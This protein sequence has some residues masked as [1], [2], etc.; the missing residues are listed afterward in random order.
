MSRQYIQSQ[1][2]KTVFQFLL[3][4]SLFLTFFL[5]LSTNNP[6][7][8]NMSRTAATMMATFAIVLA[9]LTYVYGGYQLGV[10]KARPVAGSSR[11]RIT[12]RL[13]GLLAQSP[14]LAECEPAT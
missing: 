7:I 4:V 10:R 11:K 9:I 12:W 14:R 8:I 5:L 13:P 6:Q 1:L 2:M 3:Y